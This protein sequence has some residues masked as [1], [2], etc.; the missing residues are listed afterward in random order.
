MVVFIL[1]TI[2]GSFM[3]VCIYRMPR[4][5]SV[6]RPGS[7]CPSCGSP[8]R[9]YDNIPIL[10]FLILRGKCRFCKNKISLRYL[11]VEVLTGLIYVILF[12]HFGLTPKFFILLYLT[13]ALIVVSFIDLEFREIPD[14]ITLSGIVLG[15]ILAA[16]YP[17]LLGQT[18]IFPAL[19]GSIL[20]IVAG[21]GSIYALGFFGEFIFKKEAMGGG[22]V[23]LMAMIGAF[24]GWK[25]VAL[26]F[27][28]APF[29]GSLVGIVSK[30][31]KG[32]EIIAYGPH[33]SLAAL[34]AIV[35]GETI[36]RKL[37]IGG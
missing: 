28:M 13:S 32:E 34:V 1:G 36:L 16:L 25:L 17:P 10:S 4:K 22:D 23:K 35:W 18:K 21:G 15:L 33:L 24:L 29:F 11:T 12:L 37:F 6:V 8:V 5:E 2:C 14:E 7:H 19:L 30:I 27:F 3:N 9:W 31:K 26:T 20:G